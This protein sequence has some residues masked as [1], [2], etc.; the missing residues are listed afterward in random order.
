VQAA[1][2]GN[3]VLGGG[4]DE[5]L[6]AE[7][8]RRHGDE[9]QRPQEHGAGGREA[10]VELSVHGACPLDLHLA[11]G[12]GEEVLLQHPHLERR[13]LAVVVRRTQHACLK[14]KCAL[15]PFL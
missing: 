11:W 13:R 5:G 2:G 12:G 8:G 15:G 10:A 14:G 6:E 7:V 4:V 1:P 9:E 3:Q